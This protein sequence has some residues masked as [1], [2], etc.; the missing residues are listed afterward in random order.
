MSKKDDRIKDLEEKVLGL[1]Y[2]LD[3]VET[4]YEAR[5]LQEK[6]APQIPVAKP[7]PL[8]KN[9]R[10]WTFSFEIWPGAWN[11][12]YYRF[13]W[14]KH[15]GTVREGQINLGPIGFSWYREPKRG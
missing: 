7:K 15:N 6:R 13:N 11:L 1:Q 12:Y 2:E 8:I 10:S 3:Y 4:H 5:I 9:D 14:R